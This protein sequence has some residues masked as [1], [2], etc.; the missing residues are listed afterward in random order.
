M[1]KVD[2]IILEL[3]EYVE[4]LKNSNRPKIIFIGG[5]PGAGKSLLIN[6]ALKDF[7]MDEFAIIEPDLYRKYFKEAK[8]VE[9]TVEDANRIEMELLLHALKKHKNIIH[10]SSLRAFEYIDYLINNTILPLGYDVYL[11]IIV[12]NE[13]TSSLSTYERYIYDKKNNEPFPR[14]NKLEYLQQANKGFE[15][16]V[17]F[18][19]YSD[20]F[21]DIC[22]FKRGVNKS[23]PMKIDKVE[24]GLVRTVDLE[25]ESQRLALSDEE[26]NLRISFIKN[27][28]TELYEQK[29]FDKMLNG[30]VYKQINDL[31][32]KR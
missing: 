30:I 15:L 17:K 11:Y 25:L 31:S 22:V 29:E 16:A 27:N 23:L 10:I 3:K 14:L 9:E 8:T 28:L 26:I 32:K 24:T 1:N 20:Y 5:V 12:T 2:L 18:F 7:L 21:K 19:Q 4:S 13:I 6:R